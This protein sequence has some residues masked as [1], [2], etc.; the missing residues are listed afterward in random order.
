MN[1]TSWLVVPILILSLALA[2]V[3]LY[4][5]VVSPTPVMPGPAGECR[6]SM[7]CCA[8]GGSSTMIPQMPLPRVPVVP[9]GCCLPCQVPAAVPV[10]NSPVCP[11]YDTR[12]RGF[13]RITA[14]NVLDHPERRLVFGII[15]DNPGIEFSGLARDSGI[16]INTLRYH[17]DTLVYHGKVTVSRG[18][19]IFRYFENHGRYSEFERLALP[20]TK[21]PV[22]K[23]LLSVIGQFPG[24]T[25]NSLADN[26]G[27][28]CPT[29]RW[30]IQR[31]E[32]DGIVRSARE[33]RNVCYYLTPEA[34]SFFMRVDNPPEGTSNSCHTEEVS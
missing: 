25:Q 34:A 22:S 4:Q 23:T 10:V 2:A 24:V 3:P 13:R 31:F 1:V 14:S 16:N 21:N 29:V 32:S 26:V 19:G 12:F 33:G 27:I 9:P 8:N 18:R 6:T 28:T 11:S 15:R 20:Y 17:I 5:P 30:H 7:P